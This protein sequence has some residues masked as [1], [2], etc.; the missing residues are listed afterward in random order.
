MQLQWK[1]AHHAY[2]RSA[3]HQIQNQ[4]QTLELRLT[5]DMP[6]IGRVLCC[7]GQVQ[8]RS[9]EWRT[10]TIHVSG[11]VNVW[12]L[13]VPE[14]GSEP[15]TI[16]SWIPFQMKWDLPDGQHEGDI[17]VQCLLRFLDARVVSGVVLNESP[18]FWVSK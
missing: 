4:E 8:L 12:V 3:V 6:D 1:S 9:K 2:L 7:W 10:D 18:A 11:G 15:R 16:E 13:Y 5:E 14:D 17:R